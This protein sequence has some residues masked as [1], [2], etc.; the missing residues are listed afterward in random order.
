MARQSI[1]VGFVTG[2]L[3]SGKT[4][5]IQKALDHPNLRNTAVIVNEF[6]EISLDHLLVAT[7]AETVIEL[8]NGCICCTIHADLTLTLRDLYTRRQLGEVPP[9]DYVLVETTGLA[10]P[11]PL[12]HTLTVNPIFKGVFHPDAVI[13]C[14]DQINGVMSLREFQTA[15]DQVAM[16]D[17][18][19]LTK[20]DIARADQV[21]ALTTALRAI[22][23]HAERVSMVAGAGDPTVLFRRGLY[24][25]DRHTIGRWLGGGTDQHRHDQHHHPHGHDHG[26]AYASHVLRG[27]DALSLAGV[28]VFLDRLL[29][30]QFGQVL[31]VKGLMGFREKGGRPA[32]LHGIQDRV[33]PLVWLDAWP[34]GDRSSRLVVIG[35][36]LDLNGLSEAFE[37]WCA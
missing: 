8:R 15:G 28:M 36:T 2:F 23:P 5:L 11:G 9:F 6:G 14:V 29:K 1:P 33:H 16:A 13:T 12:V 4:T 17:V 19:V 20:G 31:R 22:N 25:P 37:S 7:S 24:Q 3:G 10:D 26:V 34:D 32:V 27:S 21:A 35:R 30:G 18:L